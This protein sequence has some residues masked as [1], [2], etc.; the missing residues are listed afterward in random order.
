VI[1]IY[2]HPFARKRKTLNELIKIC[3]GITKKESP[4]EIEDMHI[5]DY[6][7]KVKDSAEN[8]FKDFDEKD[9]NCDLKRLKIRFIKEKETLISPMQAYTLT[10]CLIDYLEIALHHIPRKPEDGYSKDER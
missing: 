5:A 2:D 4:G 6:L 8:I 9:E 3:Y 7:R 10:A 1:D